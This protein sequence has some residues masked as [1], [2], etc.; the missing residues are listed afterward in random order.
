MRR[1][2]YLTAVA[3]GV[4]LAGGCL[5]GGD[6][7]LTA[8]ATRTAAGPTEAPASTP[9]AT[10]ATDPDSDTDTATDTGDDPATETGDEPTTETPTPGRPRIERANLIWGATGPDPIVQNGIE[11]AGVES[12]ILVGISYEVTLEPGEFTPAATVEIF[13]EAGQQIDA[14]THRVPMSVDRARTET[15][16]FWLAVDTTGYDA[17]T[18]RARV[19][20][21]DEE[22]GEESEPAEFSFDLVEPL[23]PS[24]VELLSAE[25]TSVPVDE[26]FEMALTVRSRTDR[27]SSLSRDLIA[28]L[29]EDN[30]HR[31]LSDISIHLP[32]RTTI[33][34]RFDGY[35]LPEPGPTEFRLRDTDLSWEIVGEE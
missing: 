28:L 22:S 23:D 34:R 9:Q 1:R 2:T 4:G 18:Y 27:T 21:H 16:P 15:L 10:T 31:A 14:E 7:E 29:G 12:T 20:M 19:S 35:R 32:A 6:G 5:S 13:H 8:T 25:P 30:A 11:Q 3:T 33:T 17:G 24:D 26:P